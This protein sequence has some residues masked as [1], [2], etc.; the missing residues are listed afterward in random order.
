MTFIQQLEQ[1]WA[2]GNT[3]LQVGLDPDPQ[4]FPR[5]LDGKPDAIFQFCRDIVDATAPYACS[6]KPQIAYFAAHRA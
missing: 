6:F 2:A 5:E 3:L 1:A 4:R